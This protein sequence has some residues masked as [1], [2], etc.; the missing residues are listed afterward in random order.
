[1]IK[2]KSILFVI[3]FMI[4]ITAFFPLVSNFMP[5]GFKHSFWL[6]IWFAYILIFYP[7][8]L[9][10]KLIILCIAYLIFLFLSL[11]TYWINMIDREKERLISESI[12]I[13]SAIT[14]V[15]FFHYTKDYVSL[16]KLSLLVL[17]FLFITALLTIYSASIDPLFVRNITSSKSEY[18]Q[19]E[20]TTIHFFRNLGG[21]NYAI[22]GVFMTLFSIIVYYYKN[23]NLFSNR[24]Y[25]VIF[26]II[27][28]IALLMTQLFA[29]LF[30]AILVFITSAFGAKKL[31]KSIIIIIIFFTISQIIPNKVYINTFIAL[32]DVFK[33]QKEISFKFRD[34][35]QYMEFGGSLNQETTA[36]GIRAK[37]FPML[38]ESYIQSPLLGCFYQESEFGRGYYL[39]GYHIHWANKLTT[40]GII[41][42][43][44][45]L[46]ILYTFI[47]KSLKYFNE[48]YKFIFLIFVSSIF[49]YGIFKTIAGR[50]FWYSFFILSTGFYYLPL[51]KNKKNDEQYN[52][53]TN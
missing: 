13:F 16:A 52:L 11:N 23:N 33:N 45:F 42:T 27:I 24:K 3:L 51:L 44:F 40:T 1:M 41:G 31:K 22:S 2:K 46:Y 25:I 18:S 49:V 48:S 35:A 8:L 20:E 53:K 5:S 36:T 30:I 28:F 39:Y 9:A 6:L 14:I 21:A 19:I 4:L 38:M 47:I 43:L 15:S 34:V 26:G 37:R 7:N 12:H 10:N 29:N 32:S 50:E 17:V